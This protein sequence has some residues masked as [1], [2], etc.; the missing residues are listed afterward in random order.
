M[1]TATARVRE[2]P[3]ERIIFG[4]NLKKKRLMLG[5]T[6]PNLFERTGIAISHISLIEN[7]DTNPSLDVMV[8]LATSVGEE[9]IDMLKE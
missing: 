6:Q 1:G 7:A 5:L 2:V 8:A 4:K 3:K 9:L